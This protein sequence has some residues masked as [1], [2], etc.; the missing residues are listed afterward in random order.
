[1]NISRMQQ[2]I[3]NRKTALQTMDTPA[4]PNLSRCTLVHKR[5]KIGPEFWPTQRAAIRLGIATH[6]VIAV[7]N[8]WLTDKDIVLSVRVCV[9]VSACVFVCMSR[10]LIAVFCSFL[11]NKTMNF[12]KKSC[13]RITTTH[14]F[15]Y[16]V[17]VH[18]SLRA[19]WCHVVLCELVAVV[20]TA[21]AA[22]TW[23]GT[24]YYVEMLK[25]S[26]V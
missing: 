24:Q 20:V 16:H 5:R 17:I 6:L 7:V 14:I 18:C 22:T 19:V 10:D 26:N 4:Q 21:A 1:M 9:C 15:W 23:C 2:D 25:L 8:C 3:I 12:R 11:W 13:R